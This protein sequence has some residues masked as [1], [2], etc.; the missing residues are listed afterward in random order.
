M[1]HTLDTIKINKPLI[2]I[3]ENVKGFKTID[4]GSVYNYL[5]TELET[6]RDNDNTQLYEIFPHV[7]NTKDYGIPQNR[8]RLYIVGITNWLLIDT[9]KIPPK[10]PMKPLEDFIIDKK[11][12]EL[13]TNMIISKKNLVKF[14]IKFPKNIGIVTHNSYY[15]PI[16][17]VSPTLTTQCGSFFIYPFNRKITIQECLSLQGFP[18]NFKVIIS[19]IQMY[20]Q[21]GNSMSINVLKVIF[22]EIFRCTLLS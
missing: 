13:S 19:N 2:F 20:K 1:N 11:V 8:E 22:K 14:S 15:N 12:Y 18:K 4:G 3:L 10:I 21:I 5:L 9:F 7:Y 17:P 16:F 6:I